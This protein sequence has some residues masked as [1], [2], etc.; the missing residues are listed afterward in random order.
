MV[1]VSVSKDGDLNENLKEIN[2]VSF[3][4]T[5]LR[6]ER[7]PGSSVVLLSSDRKMRC[8]KF[9]FHRPVK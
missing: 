2:N 4:V 6:M 3:S 5:C 9:K 7:P 1:Q 8:V